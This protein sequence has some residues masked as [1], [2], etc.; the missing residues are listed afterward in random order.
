MAITPNGHEPRKFDQFEIE[1][2]REKRKSI[3]G[4]LWTKCNECGFM[5]YTKEFENDLRVCRKCGAHA[6]LNWR[7]RV[8]ITLDEGTFV[9]HDA[10][11]EPVDPLG[12]PGYAKSVA[13]YQQRCGIK[14]AAVCGEGRLLGHPVQ[15]GLTDFNF[16]AGSMG[17]VVGEKVTRVLERAAETGMPALIVSGSGGGARMHEGALSLM[18][19][20]KASAAAAKLERARV[21]YLTV[22]THPSM[23]GVQA[24]Y[25]SLGDVILAEPGALIGFTG[26]RVIEQSLRIKLPD[27]FQ[28]AEFQ[29]EHGM[30]DLVVPRAELKATLGRLLEFFA[31]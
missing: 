12:F 16:L 29:L 24:S 27:G 2:A 9:E 10:D 18:Q 17:S 30:V 5:L 22:L 21:P 28:S 26:P 14:E 31:N 15:F 3:P 11:L 25:A 4:D 13:K 23:A 1:A 8:A 6:N 19:M 7:E 20:A